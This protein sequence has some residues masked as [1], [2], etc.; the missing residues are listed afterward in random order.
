MYST[1]MSIKVFL[2]HNILYPIH[3]SRSS[4]VNS[5][6]ASLATPVAEAGNAL[7]TPEKCGYFSVNENKIS[8]FQYL[9][10]D[11]LVLM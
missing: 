4:C 1:K 11:S 6:F 9:S 2:I 10:S 7:P 8:D 5:V 3:V